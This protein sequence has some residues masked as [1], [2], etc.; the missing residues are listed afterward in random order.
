MRD[1]FST[2]DLAALSLPGFPATRGGWDVIAEREGW[3][4]QKDKVRERPAR[5]G[6]LEY[7]VELLPPE[8][9]VAYAAR[10]IAVVDITEEDAKSAGESAAGE[11]EQG[12]LPA[13]EGRDA[14]LAIVSAADRLAAK[15]GVSRNVADRLFARI[16]NRGQ[17]AI[18]PWVKQAIRKI[19]PG[20][21]TRWRGLKAKGQHARLADG[22][23][24][25][26]RGKGALDAP[27]IRAFI[28][29]RI[30][31]Q[32]WLSA[33][34]VQ[35][36]L[37]AKFPEK[38]PADQPPARSVQHFLKRLKEAEKVL[39]TRVTNPDKWKSIYRMSGTNSHPVSRLNELWQIDASPA[40][41]LC[42][43]G[44]HS[45]YLCVDIFSRR[46]IVYVSKTPRA[47]AVALLMRRAMLAWGVPELVKTDNGSDFVAKTTKRMFAALDIEVEL[48]DAF[49][50]EQKAHVERAVGTFQHDCA[51]ILPG[52]IGHN[53]ADR[54]KIR[55]RKAFA[56]RLG[57][58]DAGAFKI[59][60]T[61][62]QLQA[63][64]DDW[65][66]GRYAHR[67]HAGIKGTRRRSPWRPP[68]PAKSARSRMFARSTSC[69]RRWPAPTGCASSAS[70]A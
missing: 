46:L 60:L 12:F 3:E 2:T 51:A 19:S 65:T 14:R 16:Y 49:C 42:V 36:L 5:G 22:R 6:G 56:Q 69:W 44:R 48:A 13:M 11:A 39:L 20:S 53:V 27:E 30:A 28:L 43:D 58:D 34:H 63:D 26:R 66:S 54:Q 4:G 35:G 70:R 61:A 8:A 47:A 62:K 64:C 50:P 37:Q 32:P 45:V 17:I 25:A 29:S 52:F 1:W 31:H 57:V 15:A 7:H 23:G 9:L 24:A 55:E 21:L 33:S 38:F 67:P 18:G 41:V 59:E 10:S 40:D 68:T